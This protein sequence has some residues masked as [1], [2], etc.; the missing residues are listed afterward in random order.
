MPSLNDRFIVPEVYSHKMSFRI[1]KDYGDGS[2]MAINEKEKSSEV[3]T[4]FFFDQ[5]N[6]DYY[7]EKGEIVWL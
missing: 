5:R 3:P 6:F 1:E 7:A 2:Y 4:L